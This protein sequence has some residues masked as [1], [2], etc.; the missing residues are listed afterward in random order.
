MKRKFT[1]KYEFTD[2]EQKAV[3]EL[4][5]VA[6]KRRR[7]MKQLEQTRLEWER[8]IVKAV[9]SGISMRVTAKYGDCN[10]SQVSRLAKDPVEEVIREL[11][12]KP[13]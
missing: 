5:S 13:I 7:L 3:D 10:V 11:T 9:E 8:A 1:V 4:R 6:K 2:D 12:D